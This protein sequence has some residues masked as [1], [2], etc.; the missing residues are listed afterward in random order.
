VTGRRFVRWPDLFR[1]PVG[2]VAA[3]MVASVLVLAL[4]GPPLWG[5]AAAKID[6]SAASQGSTAAHPLG[7]DV[8]GRDIL[9][10]TLVAARLSVFLAVLASLLGA[11]VGIPI[12][13][14]PSLVGRRLGRLITSAISLAVAFPT[15][16]LAIFVASIVGLGARGAVIGIAAAVAPYFARLSQTLAASVA[17]ADYIAAARVLGIGRW[18]LMGRHMLPNVAEPLLLTLMLTMGDALLALAGL[19]LLGVGVQPPSYDWGGMLTDG[20]LRIYVTPIVVVGPAVAIIF[21][22]LGFN[23]LGESLARRAARRDGTVPRHV[24]ASPVALPVEH[25]E[26]VDEPGD[27]GHGTVL[28][29]RG[30]TVAFPGGSFPVRDVSIRVEPGEIVGIV[31]E[32]GSGKSL[33]AMAIAELLPPRAQATSERR[34]LFGRDLASLGNTSRRRL[35][36]RSLAIVYQD[37]MASLNPALRIDRQLGEVAEV[38]EGLSRREA[39]RRSVERLRSVRIGS[40]ERRARNYPHELSGGMRQR[41]MIAMGLMGTPQLIIADEPTTA[42]DV[43]VQQQI[44]KLLDDIGTSTGAAAILI[45]HDIAVVSQLCQ[46]VLV[47][48]AG[49]VVE[50]LDVPTLVRQPA[51]PYTAALLASVPTME[52]D[53]ERPLVSIPGRAVGPFDHSPGCPFAPRC[54]AAS[55]RCRDELPELKPLESGHRVACWHPNSVVPHEASAWRDESMREDALA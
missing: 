10:R 14:L 43:T 3:L 44:L 4:I 24:P 9:D 46:R 19:S 2:V 6:V 23:L 42:L 45:S 22:A 16:L 33:T 28:D 55:D 5:H 48:Y 53:R 27:D 31:G 11:G 17:G 15:L 18:R 25:H 13:V 35:L 38:H 1:S 29:V 8:L 30:L 41:V 50:E 39:R 34:L 20:L 21:A 36:G 26:R 32:S 12:G 52:S 47:M 37:P 54:P 40:P 7:T 49:R 51:H